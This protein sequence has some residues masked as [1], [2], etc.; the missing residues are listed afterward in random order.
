MS[1]RAFFQPRTLTS[2]SQT[3]L[4]ALASEFESVGVAKGRCLLQAFLKAAW[5]ERACRHFPPSPRG[6]RSLARDVFERSLT[7]PR[8][9][10]TDPADRVRGPERGMKQLA[11]AR[12]SNSRLQAVGASREEVGF[13]HRD[14]YV[15][16]TCLHLIQRAQ[17]IGA[18]ACGWYLR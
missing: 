13:D 15:S 2:Q 7:R 17:P 4:H 18:W 3:E 1:D 14:L 8:S 9:F 12:Q 6:T 10:M 16:P 11:D 5:T